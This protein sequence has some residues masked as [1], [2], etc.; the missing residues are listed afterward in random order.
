VD[1]LVNLVMEGIVSPDE[2]A[3]QILR[4]QPRRP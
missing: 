2:G 4:L 1:S 3:E